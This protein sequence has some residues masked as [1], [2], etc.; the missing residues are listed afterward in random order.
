RRP[1]NAFLIFCKRHRSM[2]REKNPDLDNRSVTRILGD[3]WANLA[4]EKKSVYT[5]LAK[6]YKDAFMKANPDYK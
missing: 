1:M 3:L 5:T 4:E 6:Q 2:V